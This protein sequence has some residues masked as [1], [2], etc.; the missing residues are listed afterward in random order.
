MAQLTITRYRRSVGTGPRSV[1]SAVL[2]RL[3]PRRAFGT[4]A[5]GVLLSDRDEPCPIE[6]MLLEHAPTVQICQMSLQSRKLN[7]QCQCCLK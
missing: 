4:D 6:P 3:H 1:C 5:I 2:Q 7:D